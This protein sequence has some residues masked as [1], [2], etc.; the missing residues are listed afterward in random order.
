MF[1]D[2][3]RAHLAPPL[4]ARMSSIDS[5]GYPHTVPLWFD[6]DGDDLV[7]ISERNTAKTRHVLANPK[8][9][10]TIG[11]DALPNGDLVPGYLIKGVFAVEE[12]PGFAWLRRITYRYETPERAEKDLAEW[13]QLDM[14]V[15][16]LKVERVIKVA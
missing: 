6:V 4:I 2:E 9:A 13:T 3:M 1:T 10:V 12:D 14:I 5:N 11:G 8:G 7:I 16:R 15:L